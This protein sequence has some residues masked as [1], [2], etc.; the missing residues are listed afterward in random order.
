[1]NIHPGEQ[2]TQDVYDGGNGHDTLSA[3][4]LFSAIVLNLSTAQLEGGSIGSDTAR[5]FES[6]TGTGRADT[7]IGNAANN[8]LKGTF[9]NDQI[10]GGDGDDLL[11]GGDSTDL[12]D[13]GDGTDECLNGETVLNCEAR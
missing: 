7:L 13:G 8:V 6:A 9:G 10:E 4:D 11:D 1:V 3:F 5:S 2:G 12:L